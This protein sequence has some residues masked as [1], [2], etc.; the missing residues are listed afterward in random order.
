MQLEDERKSRRKEKTED[1]RTRRKEVG[2]AGRQGK[3]ERV[4]RREEK[5]EKEWMKGKKKE[6]MGLV[7]EMRRR[8]RLEDER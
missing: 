8:R 5:R 7:D 1:W 3:W 2:V 6:K 4:R